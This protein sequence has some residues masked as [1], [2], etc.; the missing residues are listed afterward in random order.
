M[1]VDPYERFVHKLVERKAAP[2]PIV[3][4]A[5]VSAAERER[6][7]L[8][9]LEAAAKLQDLE[10]AKLEK[11]A[12][13][14]NAFL[15]KYRLAA[16]FDGSGHAILLADDPQPMKVSNLKRIVS[17][18]TG[19]SLID[20]SSDRRGAS[21]AKARQI[22][23]WAARRYSPMSLP[24]IGKQIGRDHSTVIHAIAR[25]DLAIED[26]NLVAADMPD[27]WV[28]VLWKTHWPPEDRRIRGRRAA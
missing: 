25:V 7:K 1:Y 14:H 11:L 18:V 20:L 17:V 9:Q 16:A 3:P 21:V 19:I 10:R 26:L 13:A 4:L 12:D 2:A 27:V 22:F 23:C 15:V 24:G 5:R 28:A 8:A 6:I